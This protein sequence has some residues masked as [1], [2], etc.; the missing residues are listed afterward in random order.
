LKLKNYQQILQNDRLILILGDMLELG[1][2]SL[3]LHQEVLDF[4]L[5]QKPD[6][7]ILVGKNFT[8]SIANYVAKLQNTNLIVYSN[9]NLIACSIFGLLQNKDFI[10][11]KGSRG[12]KMENIINYLTSLC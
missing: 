11:I 10:Y 6:L 3:E 8:K 12:I 1:E 9:S 4:A 7:L 5:Q 2:K